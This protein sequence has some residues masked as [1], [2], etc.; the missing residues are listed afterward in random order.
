MTVQTQKLN[1]TYYNGNNSYSDGDIE[2][3]IL[4]IT[5]KNDDFTATLANDNRWAVLYH[6]TPLR[7]NL[8]EWYEFNRDS[9]LLEIGAG[10]GALTGMFCEKV[11][12][13]T[14]VELSK[15]RAE[16]IANRT[17]DFDNLEIIVGNL[18]AITFD[19][20]F[21]YITLIGVLEY[22]GRFTDGENPYRDFLL[23][24]KSLLKPNGK[25]IIAIENKFGIKY[26]AGARE[27]HSGI[28]FDSIENYP[29]KQGMETFGKFELDELIK[30]TG[31]TKTNFYYPMPDYKIPKTIFSDKYLPKIG[32]LY[33][34]APNYDQER[35][36][37]FN[38]S[39]ALN[40]LI[41]NKQFDF[42]ANSFIVICG[43]NEDNQKIFANYNRQN[44][45]KFQLET[46]IIEEN[47][48]KYVIKTPLTKKA[49]KHINDIYSNY[50]LLKENFSDLQNIEV[51]DSRIQ[52]E[53]IV[54]DY[55][56]GVNL[57]QKIVMQLIKRNKNEFKKIFLE[58]VEFIRN[59]SP[60]IR[61]D[62]KPNEETAKIFGEIEIKNVECSNI[63]GIDL[64]FDNIVIGNN[65]KHFIFDYEWTF[66][67]SLPVNYIITRTILNFL[68]KQ[69]TLL[70]GFISKKEIFE[71]INVSETE[72]EKYWQMEMNLQK[73]VLGSETKY[74]QANTYDKE[75]L[76]IEENQRQKFENYNSKPPK[77]IFSMKLSE[78]K[79]L[80][81]Y[82]EY[83]AK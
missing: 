42:F 16:I 35:Y 8:L 72:A 82:K 12:S 67:D 32:M 75:V 60:I 25:L 39:L 63:Y 47:S 48:K 49:K 10:C 28:L 50:I 2:N 36:Q 20:K 70:K 18:N 19:K 56:E 81:L 9:D 55:A 37:L 54:F 30:S 66:K 64:I 24:A 40:N 58:Y 21:D 3:E 80:T 44:D 33:N 52:G 6:L 65:G 38:E 74:Y 5:S 69:E 62:F 46:S 27:D 59:L 61:K 41:L 23:K 29:K 57:Y 78:K 22:A 4:E 13:V 26:W 14:A 73:Y 7:R 15:K 11:K 1:L 17:K 53:C 34:N 31:F 45:L 76:K 43:N 83:L 51:V 77:K 79:K 71:W 68:Y